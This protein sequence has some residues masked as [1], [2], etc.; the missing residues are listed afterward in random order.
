ML[1]RPATS[2]AASRCSSSCTA[3]AGRS[4]AAPTRST[5]PSVEAFHRAAARALAERGWARDLSAPRRGRA[6]RRALRLSPRRSLR[7]LSVGPR[8]GVAPALGRHGAARPRH[9]ALLRGAARSSSISCAATSRTSSAGPTARASTV[10]L[11]ARGA[12]LRHARSDAGRARVLAAARGGASARC[13]RRRSRWLRRARKQDRRDEARGASAALAKPA[14]P[15]RRRLGRSLAL[16]ARGARSRARSAHPRARLPPRGRS[17]STP[18]A[19][20]NPALCIATDS[21]RRRWSRC[22]S[23]STCS[24]SRVVAR[25]PA[26]STLERDAC[27]ITFDDGYRDVLLRARPVL[28]SSACRRR[29]SCRP[30]TLGTGRAPA[31]RSAL[32]RRWCGRA[33]RA[34]PRAARATRQTALAA[35][36]RRRALTAADR[37][38]P[39]SSS[40]P[41]PPPRSAASPTRSSLLRRRLASTTAR[42]CSRR[43]AARARRR[44]LGDW[45]PHRRP[46]GA[47]ARAAARAAPRAERPRDARALSGPPA[48][49][50]P[51]ATAS[52][53]RALV[54]GCARA[55]YPA[56]SPPAIAPT[57][58]GDDPLRIAARS[59]GR[60]TRA[61]PR[62]PLLAVALGRAPARS[63]RHARP[64]PPV[65]GEVRSRLAATKD[66]DPSRRR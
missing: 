40:T 44:R 13:R 39:S 35:R 37:P 56:P 52:T 16:S 4:T 12:A 59:C 60:R 64:H 2:R 45:R 50:S 11:R 21:F 49:S 48:A 26:R 17:P 38:P 36:A 14:S 19:P 43:R 42:A 15:P 8:P 63:V 24:R 65:D 57:A 31:S 66:R 23:A 55:G 46:R 54:D 58:R 9:R 61:R 51:T 29:C 6:A 62:R 41:R 22:A 25:S 5:A 3:S 10:R 33:A 18:T 47:H 7:L 20:V 28:A 34:A 1:T 53:A 27:A 30:A 32:R